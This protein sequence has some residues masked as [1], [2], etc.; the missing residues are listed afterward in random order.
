MTYSGGK[1]SN[2]DCPN[3]ITG[4][5]A[6]PACTNGVI[7]K[8]SWT[9]NLTISGINYP[10]G[11]WSNAGAGPFPYVSPTYHLPDGGAGGDDDQSALAAQPDGCTGATG[12][13]ATVTG[14]STRSTSTPTSTTPP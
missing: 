13:T 5:A 6:Y 2:G 8:L 11:R 14:C 12:S 1:F 7:C 3:L 4:N 10:K 9:S